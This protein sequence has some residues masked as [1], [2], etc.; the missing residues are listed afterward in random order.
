MEKS[1]IANA[2]RRALFSMF[3]GY[4]AD[5]HK[6]NFYADFGFPEHLTFHDY[7]RIYR[8]NG[9]AKACVMRIVDKCWEDYP[10]LLEADDEPH[11]ETAQEKAMAQAVER[12]MLW[13]KLSEAHHKSRVGEYSGVIFRFADNKYFADPVDTVPGGYDGLVEVIPVYQEQLKPSDWDTDERSPTYGHPT[14]YQ[15]NEAAVRSSSDSENKQRS[16]NVHPDRVHIWSKDGTVHGTPALEAAYND[17]ITIEKVVGAGGE[18]FWKNAKSSPVLNMDKDASP[19]ALAGMLGVPED[20]IADKMGE[21]VEDW[22]KGFDKLLM[23]QGI[24]TKTLGI[25]LPQPEEFVKVALQSAAASVPIPLKILIGSQS[26][27][28]AST[29]DSD[30]WAKTCMTEREGNVIPN[31]RRIVDKLVK[32][33][34]FPERDWVVDWSDLTESSMDQKIERAEKMAGTNQKNVAFGAVFMPDEMREVLGMEPIDQ[35]L[36]P[37]DDEP[38]TNSKR[39]RYRVR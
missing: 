38:V 30:E 4:F 27:E 25:T 7:Y 15:F 18:G 9:I 29:E 11:D 10:W 24:E 36:L 34:V 26:G 8:R 6:H 19:A 13:T 5:T 32:F 20:Q 37:E 22:Q 39:K 23:L 21:V 14:M 35:E 16:F 12:L 31:I 17:L 33:R 3:P 1:F 28:R 2:M